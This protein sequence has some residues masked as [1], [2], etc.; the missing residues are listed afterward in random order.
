MKKQIFLVDAD[1]TILDFHAA[2]D[3]AVRAAFENFSVPWEDRFSTVFTTLNDGLWQALERKEL[4]RAELI[5]RR[6]PLYLKALD[7]QSVDGDEFNVK[8]LDHLAT[9]PLYVA[10][11]QDFLKKL[12]ERGRVFIVTNGTERI[13]RSRFT[14]SKLYELA[15]EVFVSDTIGADKP[16]PEYTRYVLD[17][18]EGFQKEKAVW[19]G[20]SL[21]ADIKAANEAGIDS[22]WYNPSK[23]PLKGGITPT[24]TVSSFEEIWQFL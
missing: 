11:A 17:H 20:D 4:T 1:D 7:M 10:G 22:I 21:S 18:I 8:Y 19:I 23:K 16:A 2:S 12:N 5:E 14:I 13:Q 6:F 3:N 15:E 24:H 9:H